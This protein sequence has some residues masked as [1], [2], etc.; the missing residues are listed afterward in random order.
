MDVSYDMRAITVDKELYSFNIRDAPARISDKKY[1]LTMKPGSPL[2]DLRVVMR[3]T[4]VD[5]LWEGDIIQESDGSIY[6]VYYYGG[7]FARGVGKSKLLS[8]LGEYKKVGTCFD[9]DFPYSPAFLGNCLFK[10]RDKFFHFYDIVGG[11]RGKLIVLGISGKVNPEE[12]QQPVGTSHN[13]VDLY[14]GDLVDG[15]PVFMKDGR[16][17]INTPDG[18]VDV[19]YKWRD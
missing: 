17:V 3:G 13:G 9:F 11:F 14:Y 18:L 16:P 12:V 4:D 8:E 19:G 5:D 6:I 7:F 10:Y 1:C 2:L 15:L